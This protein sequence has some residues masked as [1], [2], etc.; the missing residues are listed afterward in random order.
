VSAARTG[1]VVGALGKHSGPGFPLK[2][3]LDHARARAAGCGHAVQ[4]YRAS[5]DACIADVFPDGQI[6][7][8]WAGSKIA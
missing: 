8:T 4:V 2:Q 6:D 1:F 3:A 7:L 5:D